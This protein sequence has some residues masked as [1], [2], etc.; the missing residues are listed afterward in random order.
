VDKFIP[1]TQGVSNFVTDPD[2]I[3]TVLL[4]N[5]SEAQLSECMKLCQESGKV[6]NVYIQTAN[7]DEEW[8]WRIE[9][10]ADAIIDAE[11]EDPTNYFINK[12]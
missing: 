2:Y 7:S 10:I 11:N 3:P 12:A 8:V 1:A 5:A 9:R 4:I 6:Y